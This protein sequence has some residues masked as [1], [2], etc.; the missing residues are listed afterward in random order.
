MKNTQ[1]QQATSKGYFSTSQVAKI[2]GLSVGTVQKLVGLN[3]L[4]AWRTEGGHRRIG[5]DSVI[6]YARKNSILIESNPV[7][8]F[9]QILI[10]EDD[11]ETAKMYK[12]F[13]EHWALPFEVLIYSSA[14]EVLIDLHNLNP[15]ILLTDLDTPNMSG[16]EFI[17]VIR[18]RKQI[19]NLP[20]IVITRLS[21]EM[22][23]Q[24]GGLDEDVVVLRK[25]LAM[26]W[27]KGFLQ[28]V[29]SIEK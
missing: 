7:N 25:P 26:D 12:R 9:A 20:I 3:V 24:N 15:K 28:G 17:K 14:I 19:K 21:D 13:F 1:S 5:I 22:I 2:F 23:R 11:E 27:L 4:Q 6:D 18:S 16:F 29:I 8:S 10:I